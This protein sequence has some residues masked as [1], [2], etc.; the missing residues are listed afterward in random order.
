MST[1]QKQCHLKMGV[2]EFGELE[3][4][5]EVRCVSGVLWGK[6]RHPTWDHTYQ[7][8]LCMPP[9]ILCG[10]VLRD[11]QLRGGWRCCVT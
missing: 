6:E 1:Y 7:L 2:G 11:D 5:R 9:S 10:M 4:Y 3:V 8:S